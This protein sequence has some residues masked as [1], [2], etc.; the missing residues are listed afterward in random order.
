[1]ELCPLDNRYKKET[2]NI[3]EIFSTFGY[4]RHRVFIE[5]AYFIELL[6]F[7]KLYDIKDDALIS[8]YCKNIYI[9]ENYDYFTKNDFDKIQSYEN[10]TNHDV[11][12]I[13]YYI[14]HLIETKFMEYKFYKEYIHFGLTSQDINNT[15]FSLMVTNCIENIVCPTITSLCNDISNLSSKWMDIVMISKTHGQPAVPTTLGKELAVF[16]ERINTELI[17]LEN[18]EITTKFGGAVGNM[19]AHY[20]A[21][22]EKKWLTFAGDFLESFNL[23]RQIYTTQIDHYDSLARIFDSVARLNVIFKDFCVDMWLYI[24]MNY[25]SQKIVETETGSST[26]PHKVNP[27]NFE[28][29]EGNIGIANS[30]FHHFSSK[31]PQSRLQRD[32][33]D[34]TVIRNVGMAFGYTMVALNSISKGIQKI[35]PNTSVIQ[36]EINKHYYVIVEGIQTILRKYQIPNGYEM[37]KE[38]TRNNKEVTKDEIN[39]FIEGLEIP[40]EAKREISNITPENYIGFLTNPK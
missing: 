2:S 10:V 8:K 31:L 26:M 15:A 20:C 28:N 29:A 7:L 13:E 34:S 1:M 38:L 17:V 32:L 14:K 9:Y 39:K 40:I 24:S 30:L 22:P 35:T 36:Q 18:I 27:I 4:T 37:M 12:A 25:L 11:K 3:R 5:L 6:R 19:N 16:I 33:T 21:F 23:Q